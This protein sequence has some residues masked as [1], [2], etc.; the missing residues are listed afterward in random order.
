VDLKDNYTVG[1]PELH[2][3][4][5]RKQAAL[6]GVNTQQIAGT[7]RTAIN[8]SETIKIRDGKDEIN[9]IVRL[10]PDARRSLEDISRLKINGRDGALIPLREIATVQSKGGTGSVRHLDRDRVITVE[11]N[12]S[13][14]R[15]PND[16]LSDVRDRISKLDLPKGYQIRY[17]GQNKEQEEAQVFLVK[18]LLSGIFLIGLILV[19]QF[20]S[21]L[22]VLTIL[23]SVVLSL[24]GVLWGLLI[25]QT[26][27][28]VIMVGIGVISLAG[29]VVNN[30]IVLIDFINQLRARGVDRFNAVV[31]S[32]VIRLR[33]V[34]L[35]AVT[36]ILALLPMTF[37]V[38]FDFVEWRWVFGGQSVEMWNPMANAVV[39]GLA[40]ATALTL[41]VVPVL[42]TFMDDL[43][44]FPGRA[45]A[46]ISKR[47][48][49]RTPQTQDGAGLQASR[50]EGFAPEPPSDPA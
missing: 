29:V 4:V 49:R 5:D 40:F 16:V 6:V 7:V 46:E 33:P 44:Q 24:I 11:A 45:S 9:V 3:E 18:A 34:L 50:Q 48:R 28:G 27:F 36:S 39:F 2:V 14:G 38:S 21:L 8:G 17:T 32:G 23:S 15:L 12:V 22:Q 47:W 19:L 37:G 31:M 25:T 42:Y 1:R 10:K 13:A 43:G 20:N 35:T 41:V 30:A 26:P